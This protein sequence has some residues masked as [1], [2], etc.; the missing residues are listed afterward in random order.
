[1]L[2]WR[3]VMWDDDDDFFLKMRTL[4]KNIMDVNPAATQPKATPETN[5][6][7]HTLGQPKPK[8][9]FVFKKKE[10]GQ[11]ILTSSLVK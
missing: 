3:E 7:I 8:K 10:K 6:G 9:I 4:E 11:T 5:M 2:G 1:M